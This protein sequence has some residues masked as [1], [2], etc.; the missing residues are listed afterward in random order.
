MWPHALRLKSK[1]GARLRFPWAVP[2]AW[3]HLW[4]G[5]CAGS[6]AAFCQVALSNLI[7]LVRRPWSRLW[8]ELLGW[9]PEIA[10]ILGQLLLRFGGRGQGEAWPWVVTL[11][12][13]TIL[14]LLEAAERCCFLC[15]RGRHFQWS[16]F[17]VRE[18]GSC[19][20]TA[21]QSETTTTWR[22]PVAGYF[23]DMMCLAHRCGMS[24]L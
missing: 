22:S 8:S 7:V 16:W 9:P 2:P 23:F 4:L 17:S 5:S 3:R 21:G 12:N 13:W 18:A 20:T 24:D 1:M 15:G 10:Q 11:S 19:P 14:C 6:L